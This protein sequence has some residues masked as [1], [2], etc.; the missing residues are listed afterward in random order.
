MSM[1]HLLGGGGTGFEATGRRERG[2]RELMGTGVHALGGDV[3][4]VDAMWMQSVSMDSMY[5]DA[6][7]GL[8]LGRGCVRVVWVS[9]GEDSLLARFAFGL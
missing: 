3:D 8:S 6:W 4:V 1:G 7:T 2:S 9:V 5:M